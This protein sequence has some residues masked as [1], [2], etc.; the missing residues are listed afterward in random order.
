MLP[1]CFH[2]L[3]LLPLLS[4]FC[5]FFS[6]I[7]FARSAHHTF[8]LSPSFLGLALKYTFLASAA[9]FQSTRAAAPHS[10]RSSQSNL[11]SVGPAA[12]RPPFFSCPPLPLLQRQKRSPVNFPTGR[13]TPEK[14]RGKAPVGTREEDDSAARKKLKRE[15]QGG[16]LSVC[17]RDTVPAKANPS[18]TAQLAQQ[19]NHSSSSSST[20]AQQH[21]STAVEKE[22]DGSGVRPSL[23]RSLRSLSCSSPRRRQSP[24]VRPS[25]HCS[26]HKRRTP[27]RCCHRA[28]KKKNSKEQRERPTCSPT[29]PRPRDRPTMP[30]VVID[31]GGGDIKAGVAGVHDESPA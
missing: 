3:A 8:S 15:T 28:S 14:P 7:P 18:V 20:A 11:Q 2:S 29:V 6:R 13:L 21:S 19:H 27:R 26:G 12:R 16:R 9:A 5:V 24:D 1:Y 23:Y 4:S 30:T 17:A 22:A 25:R 10:H 31:N